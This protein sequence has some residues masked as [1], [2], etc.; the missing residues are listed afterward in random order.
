MSHPNRSQV[1]RDAIEDRGLV[2]DDNTEEMRAAPALS[3]VGAPGGSR[4]NQP[5][6]K[7]RAGS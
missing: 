4:L 1:D 3:G 5:I 7:E 2:D 6:T